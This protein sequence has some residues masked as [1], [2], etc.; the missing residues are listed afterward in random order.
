MS[1]RKRTAPL[2][3]REEATTGQKTCMGCDAW[4]KFKC[5]NAASPFFG[6]AVDCGCRYF[7][8]EAV[9]K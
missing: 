5:F 9:K 3:A 2:T 4:D 6:G 7:R 1:E 8:T